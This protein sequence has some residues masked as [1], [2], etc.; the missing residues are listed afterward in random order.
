MSQSKEPKVFFWH[1]PDLSE[2][3]L[4]KPRSE[5]HNTPHK[6]L[7]V[8]DT[9][10][11]KYS[12]LGDSTLRRCLAQFIF[13]DR[14]TDLAEFGVC[15]IYNLDI[16]RVTRAAYSKCELEILYAN[17]RTRVLANLDTSTF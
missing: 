16:I 17:T 3:T 13:L 7:V 11:D 9:P 4:V 6:A 10:R 12:A 1:N 15:S 2:A 5:H 14:L 8:G